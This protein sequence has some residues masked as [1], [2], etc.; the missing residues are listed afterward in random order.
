MSYYEAVWKLIVPW[1][2]ENIL[3]LPYHINVFPNGSGDT[4]FN[5]V[6]VLTYFVI[7]VIFS[8]LWTIADFKRINYRKFSRW[9]LVLVRYYLGYMMLSY[10][11]AKIFK[12]QFPFPS[13]FV[14]S[15][16]YGESSPMRLIWTFMGYSTGYNYFTGGAEALAGLLLFFRRTTTYGSLVA[17]TVMSNI[18]MINFC[19]D[20]PV[21]LFSLHLLL[22]AVFILS[23]DLKR[24]VRF[25][26]LNK[27]VQPADLSPAFGNKPLRNV[28]V[29]VKFLLIAFFLF[30]IINVHYN[31]ASM[32]EN[33]RSKTFLF[34]S[35]E[36]ESFEKNHKDITIFNSDSLT[37][38]NVFMLSGG[39]WSIRM[40]NDSL[41]YF[42]ANADTSAQKIVLNESYNR[43]IRYELHYLKTDADK[44]ELN[45]ELFNDILSI[46][47]K[48][49]DK[50][51]LLVNRGFHWINEYPYNR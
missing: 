36:V 8:T 14:L 25:F 27:S 34:G 28:L 47:L 7:S 39:Y 2:G 44:I 22:M 42:T 5:Y 4:T 1:V 24:V 33:M 50:N 6:Q 48:K 43:S 3:R 13:D 10:G 45:G 20:V 46:Q 26:F 49:F 31:Y 12:T 11:F 19:Y 23:F 30:S 16:T 32:Y 21:K 17:L 41:K 9:L 38:K 35:Y 29:F 37:W 51:Y 15:E 18:V 40:M